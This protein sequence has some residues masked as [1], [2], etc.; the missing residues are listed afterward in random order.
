VVVWS[1]DLTLTERLE[2]AVC[3]P[4]LRS[5]APFLT[6]TCAFHERADSEAAMSGYLKTVVWPR[7]PPYAQSILRRVLYCAPFR[8]RSPE[9]LDRQAGVKPEIVSV[10]ARTPHCCRRVALVSVLWARAVGFLIERRRGIEGCLE[11]LAMQAFVLQSSDGQWSLPSPLWSFVA[12]SCGRR[13]TWSWRRLGILL[14]TMCC[15]PCSWSTLCGA[16][17]SQA[18][19]RS[20]C[21][22]PPAP[23]FESNF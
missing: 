9:A 17:L 3:V 6:A 18:P 23:C 22:T 10:P 2:L 4:C 13:W 5:L 19:F 14:W 11:V 20:P 15:G 7:A 8:I 12:G 16:A 1:S 21:S